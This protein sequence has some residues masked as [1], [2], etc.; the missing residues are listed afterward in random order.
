MSSLRLKNKLS[1]TSAPTKA[2]DVTEDPNSPLTGDGSVTPSVVLKHDEGDGEESS[3]GRAGVAHQH[4][5]SQCGCTCKCEMI[6]PENKYIKYWDIL[7][8]FMCIYTIFSVPFEIGV[9]A[10]Y[11]Y[12]PNETP[13]IVR[14]CITASIFFTDTILVFFRQFYA[15]R[16]RLVRGQKEIAMTYLKGWFTIDLIACF[17][18][19]VLIYGIGQDYESDDSML[20]IVSLLRMCRILRLRRIPRHNS[21]LQGNNYAY[22][23]Y[24]PDNIHDDVDS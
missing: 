9:A 7:I 15:K 10:N 3:Q 21:S 20:V 14:G 17:P 6:P 5:T 4:R 2:D 16:G 22:R 24:G 8:V 1:Y 18:G 13:C 19:D 11:C 12:G 23:E